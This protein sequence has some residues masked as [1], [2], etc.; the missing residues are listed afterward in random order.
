LFY[1]QQFQ[2]TIVFNGRLDVLGTHEL[3]H[4]QPTQA[5]CKGIQRQGW[6]LGDMTFHEILIAS[7]WDPFFFKPYEKDG[8][9]IGSFPLVGVKIKNLWNH[10]YVLVH[11]KT[12]T[13]KKSFPNSPPQKKNLGLPGEILGLPKFQKRGEVTT[14]VCL[15]GSN[16]KKQLNK[17]QRT[18]WF[19]VPCLGWWKR[20]PF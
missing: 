3:S 8:R 12:S 11:F 4:Y 10:R 14:G 19:K 15:M 17:I 16:Q 5:E 7:L 6:T 18:W 2:G 20:D 13:P 1:N 9:Q